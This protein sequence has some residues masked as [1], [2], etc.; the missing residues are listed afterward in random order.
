MLTIARPS[1]TSS[2]DADPHAAAVARRDAQAAA[3]AQQERRVRARLVEQQVAADG[4]IELDARV[5]AGDGFR[6]AVAHVA[7]GDVVAANAA[8]GVRRLGAAPDRDDAAGE[9]VI[10]PVALSLHDAQ[11]QF[12]QRRAH[13]VPAPHRVVTALHPQHGAVASLLADT[14]TDTSSVRGDL[15]ADLPQPF[16]QAGLELCE[17]R[18]D[19]R[20]SAAGCVTVTTTRL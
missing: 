12:G 8:E 11:P 3:A 19:R 18:V 4:R 6:D 15:A 13:R 20:A 17:H 16:A 10:D 5:R 9:G 14:E 1:C 2:P 7:E